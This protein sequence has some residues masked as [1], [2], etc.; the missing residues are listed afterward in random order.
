MKLAFVVDP[1]SELEPNHD[2][3]IAMIEAA[4]DLGHEVWVTKINQLSIIEGKAWARMSRIEV[5]LTFFREKQKPK[6]ISWYEISSQRLVCLDDM[7][8]VFIRKDPPVNIRYLYATYILDLINPINTLVLN[9]PR[10]LRE[11]NEKIY[12]LQFHQFMPPTIV[13]KDKEIIHDFVHTYK[14]AVLKPLGGKAGEGIL[15]LNLQDPN[16]NSII[17]I[18]THQGQE[19]VMIQ[20]FLPE[21]K[22]GDKRI[23]LLNGNPI[24]AV[25]RVPTGQEFRGN[26]AVG[27]RVEK[28]EISLQ[29][30]NMCKV[31]GKKLR[32]DG[33]YFVGI[34]IIG[35][36]LTEINV[37]SPTGIREIDSLDQKNLGQEVI[38]WVTS[39]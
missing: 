25:N 15:I 24:G 32:Q 37:T 4:Q 39:Q 7:N 34:D 3:T 30:H 5:D 26:M 11:A 31:L 27:G 9:S 36:Y 33:L 23:I 6:N 29:E 2:S 8:V 16:L 21:A 35:G 22:Y 14:T 17:E 38:K 20:Q 18:S 12:A 28:A 13:G 1:I 10:G 19:P